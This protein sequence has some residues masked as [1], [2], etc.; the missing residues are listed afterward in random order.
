MLECSVHSILFQGKLRAT[1]R[2]KL[3]TSHRLLISTA[4]PMSQINV[5]NT[6]L[7]FIAKRKLPQL[8]HRCQY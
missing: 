8:I 4:Y 6:G 5:V 3:S 2:M 1:G 7:I